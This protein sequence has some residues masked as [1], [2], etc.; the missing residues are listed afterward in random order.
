MGKQRPWGG[1]ILSDLPSGWGQ[2]P[3]AQPDLH[4]PMRI[5]CLFSLIYESSSNSIIILQLSMPLKNRDNNSDEWNEALKSSPQPLFQPPLSVTLVCYLVAQCPTLC[6]LMDCSPPGSSIHGH[7]PGKN[8]GVGCHFLLQGI[9]LTQGWNP[10]L[11][12]WQ[13][14]FLPLSHWGSLL[15]WLDN[16]N[17]QEGLNE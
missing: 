1:A 13:V 4:F 12:Y 15:H 8:T 11:L 14:G 16:Q 6:D 2:S 3:G 17:I 5:P 10:C 7:F 9:F